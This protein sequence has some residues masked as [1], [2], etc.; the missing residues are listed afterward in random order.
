MMTIQTILRSVLSQRNISL[1]PDQVLAAQEAMALYGMRTVEIYRETI[2]KEAN[3]EAVSFFTSIFKGEFRLWVRKIYFQRAK[4]QAI[5]R[6][7]T[8]GYKIYVIRSGDYSYQVLSTRDVNLNK[9]LRVLG[10]NVDAKKLSETADFI[11][12]PKK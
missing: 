12:Y 5:I 3:I 11:A 8:E 7:E 2:S 9:K 4:R 1:N 6:S 10:K